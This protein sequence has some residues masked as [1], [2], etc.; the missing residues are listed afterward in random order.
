[1]SP[2]PILMYHN[3]GTPPD[4]AKLRNLYVGAGAFARQMALLRLF[5]YRGLSMSDAMPYLH[6]EQQGRVV[7]ITFDDGYADT[8][9]QALPVLQRNG[10]SATCYA[11]SQRL[12]QHNDWDAAALNVSKPLM[13]AAQLRAWCDAGMEAGAHTRTHARLTACD[14]ATLAQEV[15][16]SKQDLEALLDRP[17]TQFC[18]PYGD[19]DARV[20]EATRRAGYAAATTTQR[21]RARPGDD[22]LLYRRVLVGR[23]TL[24]HLFLFK[25]LSAYEDK[26]G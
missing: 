12:G 13:T 5:G 8:L 15:G 9:E 10:F 6:G 16:G 17:V 26:R 2:I 7:V 21:G 24:P 4:G 1:M 23:R 25:L 18:Y 14:D 19:L 22:P 11:V 3:I 20:V